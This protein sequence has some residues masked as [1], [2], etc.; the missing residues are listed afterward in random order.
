MYALQEELDHF[1]SQLPAE[2]GL[3]TER[4]GLMVYSSEATNYVSLHTMWLL[5]HCDLYRHCVSGLRESMAN[6]AL[7]SSPRDFIHYCQRTCLDA[8]MRLCDFWSDIYHLMPTEYLGDG[9]LAVSIY[10]VAQIVLHLPLLLSLSDETERERDVS[11]NR[12]VNALQK[13]LNEALH[14]A[15]PENLESCNFIKCLKDAERL[16]AALSSLGAQSFDG[17]PRLPDRPDSGIVEEDEDEIEARQ[18]HLQSRHHMLSYIERDHEAG[19][20]NDS[21]LAAPRPKERRH[22][23]VACSLP[24]RGNNVAAGNNIPDSYEISVLGATF[25]DSLLEQSEQSNMLGGT[26]QEF[27]PW[28]PFDVEMNTYYDCETIGL[29]E[30]EMFYQG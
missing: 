17:R 13:Q 1:R 22:D 10:Q 6:E 24:R 9:N 12:N 21:S 23:E 27:Q 30:P 14:I 8:A 26:F 11:G 29:A 19:D 2:I 15:T 20:K 7:V 5:C 3:T 16:I 25:N 28:D 4:L 18:E